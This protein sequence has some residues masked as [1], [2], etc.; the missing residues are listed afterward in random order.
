MWV[1]HKK[2]RSTM[3][4]IRPTF[5]KATFFNSQRTI[6]NPEC[7]I[8]MDGLIGVIARAGG[9]HRAAR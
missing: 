7:A 6:Y 5:D 8:S 1:K 4:L 2:M 3:K 9:D